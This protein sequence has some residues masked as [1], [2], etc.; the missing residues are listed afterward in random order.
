MHLE[1]EFTFSNV[2][3]IGELYSY[4]YFLFANQLQLF[5][6]LF[7]LILVYC[8]KP[9]DSLFLFFKCFSPSY[10]FIQWKRELLLVKVIPHYYSLT[11]FSKFSFEFGFGLINIDPICSRERTES[12]P[13]YHKS[14]AY[15]FNLIS[16][17]YAF[18]W[19]KPISYRRP[20]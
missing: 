19:I 3:F 17:N 11:T 6:S 10:N 4:G 5:H 14:T 12:F 13:K 20:R 16:P 7:A 18:N 15:F 2:I 8:H 1:R 9:K